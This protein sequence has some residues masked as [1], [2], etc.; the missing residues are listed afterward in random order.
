MPFDVAL[1][2][3]TGLLFELSSQRRTGFCFFPVEFFN[4]HH[5]SPRSLSSKPDLMKVD[6]L[7]VL[8]P[9]LTEL[10]LKRGSTLSSFRDL[11]SSLARLRV[12]WL[13]ACG[14]RHLDGVGALSGLEELYLAFNDIGDLTSIALHDHLEVRCISDV[15]RPSCGTNQT[16]PRGNHSM[17]PFGPGSSKPISLCS[18]RRRQLK[19]SHISRPNQTMEAPHR[20]FCVERRDWV[21][22][23]PDRR[24]L[25]WSRTTSKTRIRSCT[26]VLAL[27]FVPS[28]SR[29]IPCPA[30]SATGDSWSTRCRTWSASTRK[31]L[32]VRYFLARGALAAR[33]LLRSCLLRNPEAP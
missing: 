25:T 20:Q 21:L 29:R 19:R 16:I 26:W 33:N 23:S 9:S 30:T 5:L 6:H 32:R 4:S 18:H 12:L 27:A 1:R 2:G 14:V 13:S 28:L 10:R 11:G 15:A 7:G 31:I 3:T 24:C 17:V 8:M 22:Y